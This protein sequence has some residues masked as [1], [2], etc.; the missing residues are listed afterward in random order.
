MYFNSILLYLIFVFM[1]ICCVKPHR[2]IDPIRRHTIMNHIYDSP[3]FHSH[4]QRRQPHSIFRLR[5]TTTALFIASQLSHLVFSAFQI[6][7]S[8]HWQLECICLFVP[9]SQ[10]LWWHRSLLLQTSHPNADWQ[11]SQRRHPCTG[12]H[13][14]QNFALHMMPSL[15]TLLHAPTT[16]PPS[17]VTQVKQLKCSHYIYNICIVMREIYYVQNN[18]EMCTYTKKQW[19]RK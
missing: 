8:R 9:P 7:H 1:F 18:C 10:D 5:S 12:E 13:D 17:T 11:V 2:H 19:K 14:E 15:A 6:K 16:I 4:P 3:I